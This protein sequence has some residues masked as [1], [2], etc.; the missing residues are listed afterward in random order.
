MGSE[1]SVFAGSGGAV[2]VFAGCGGC[3]FRGIFTGSLV[4]GLQAIP[5]SG[6]AP[7]GYVLELHTAQRAIASRFVK[8]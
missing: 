2:G 6:L 4:P 8:Q 1:R 3:W 5:V 7:G